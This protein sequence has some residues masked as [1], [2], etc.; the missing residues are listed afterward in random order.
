MSCRHL[1]RCAGC[2]LMSLA[3][4]EQLAAKRARVLEAFGDYPSLAR[5]VVPPV[6]GADPLI[7]YRTRLK[8]MVQRGRLGMYERGN[9]HRVV[10]T[11]DCQVATPMFR[12]IAQSIRADAVVGGL[13]AIDLR[14]VDDGDAPGVLV[15]LVVRNHSQ[16]HGLRQFASLLTNKHPEIRGVAVNIRGKGNPQVLGTETSL[17]LGEREVRDRVDRA[18]SYATFGAFVQAHRSQARAVSTWL[19]ERVAR[20]GSGLRVLELFGGAGGFGLELAAAG[21]QVH[22]VEA[23]APAAHLAQRAAD[24]QRLR[25]VAHAS[26]A[27]RFVLAA[28][29]ART[30]YDVVVVDPPRR[31]LTAALREAIASLA[32]RAFGYVSCC[33]ETLARDLDHFTT[34]GLRVEALEAFDMIP[35]TSEVET[36]CWLAPQQPS[37]VAILGRSLHAVF[38]DRRA[39]VDSAALERALNRELDGEGEVTPR[40][41]A[42]PSGV[43]LVERKG[44]KGPT[45]A[46]RVIALVKGLTTTHGEAGG[47]EFRRVAHGGGHSLLESVVRG[48]GLDPLVAALAA[49]GHPVL[50]APSCDPATR[51]FMAERHGL[52]RAFLHVVALSQGDE[53]LAESPLAGD[54]RCVLRSL[55]FSSSALAS[56]TTPGLARPE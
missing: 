23:F 20:L 12:A 46:R 29:R 42:T 35:Q 53:V 47:T 48:A 8:W 2:P 51:R 38:V 15:T 19:V 6:V 40:E 13:E 21:A 28:A 31:G 36:V 24:E 14:E 10:D 56:L 3:P 49:G 1:E 22:S 43:A 7:G 16:V 26:D 50:G 33:P 18:Y 30:T 44:W 11:P 5:S 4:E 55:G 32:P 37:S 27:E 9:D 39:H 45:F 34:L 41:Q 25:F 54:L 17:L 52:D